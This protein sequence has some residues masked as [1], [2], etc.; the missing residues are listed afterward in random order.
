MIG[1]KIS[2][3]LLNIMEKGNKKTNKKNVKT[4]LNK[5]TLLAI[6]E[7]QQVL[8]MYV[9][10]VDENLN[11]I[12]KVGKNIKAIIPRDEASSIVGED[13][14]V[15]EKYIVNKKGKVLPVC[16]KDILE[17][18]NEIELVMSKNIRVKSKKMDVYAFK[19]W[20]KIKRCCSRS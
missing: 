19:T 18:D 5:E 11:M 15:E 3:N 2:N 14:L 6:K 13:G 8:D 12:G 9:E 4:E 1:G 20:C 16:I 10:D 7:N 17:N